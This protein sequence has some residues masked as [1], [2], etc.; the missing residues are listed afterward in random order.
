MVEVTRPAHALRRRPRA[1]WRELV[2][3]DERGVLRR[4]ARIQRRRADATCPGALAAVGIESLAAAAAMWYRR[5]LL[6]ELNNL[7]TA[8]Y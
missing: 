8:P 1:H 2:A 4:A 5:R 6:R 7:K 3:R